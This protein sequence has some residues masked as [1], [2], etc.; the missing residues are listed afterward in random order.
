M[1]ETNAMKTWKHEGNNKVKKEM[2]YK[3]AQKFTVTF[4]SSLGIGP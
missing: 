4:F 1:V 3:E 2:K